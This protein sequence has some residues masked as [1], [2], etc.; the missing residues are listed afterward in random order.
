MWRQSYTIWRRDG[1]HLRAF[2][3][4]VLPV[5][6]KIDAGPWAIGAADGEFALFR[7]VDACRIVASPRTLEHFEVFPLP[8]RAGEGFVT[9]L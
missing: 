2:I 3:R 1:N 5:F 6:G 4:Y 8:H 9:I 7:P